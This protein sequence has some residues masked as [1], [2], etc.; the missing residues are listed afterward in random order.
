MR[1]GGRTGPTHIGAVYPGEGCPR[2]R[3]TLPAGDAAS[4]QGS[5]GLCGT[6]GP[7]SERPTLFRRQPLSQ[8]PR[9]HHGFD[10]DHGAG[11]VDLRFGGTQVAPA[12]GSNGA[13]CAQ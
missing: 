1:G 11:L 4:I 6:W 5:G 8:K 2:S 7:L 13:I 9:T 12:I 3:S 10:H